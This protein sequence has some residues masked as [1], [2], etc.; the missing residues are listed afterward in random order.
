MCQVKYVICLGINEQV[1]PG[2]KMWLPNVRSLLKPYCEPCSGPKVS[3]H[4]RRV[5]AD[6]GWPLRGVPLYIIACL[7]GQYRG[8]FSSRGPTGR[9]EGRYITCELNIPLYCPT[10]KECDLV[11][12]H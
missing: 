3:G 8:I 1:N 11:G 5:A 6:Q 4:N 10:Q 9:R 2:S 12:I 7:G